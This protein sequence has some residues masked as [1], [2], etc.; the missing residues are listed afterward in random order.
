MSLAARISG[1]QPLVWAA[2]FAGGLALTAWLERSGRIGWP[3]NV[4]LIALFALSLPLMRTAS[5]NRASGCGTATLALRA[6]QNR[7]LVWALSYVALLGV[8]LTA[9]NT[10]HPAGPVLWLLALLPSLTIAYYVWAL[11]RYLAEEDDEYQRMRQVNSALIATGLLLV[12]ASTWG[13][14][15]TFGVAPH[16]EGWWSVAVWAV[17]LGLGN[18]VQ[19]LRERQ[20]DAA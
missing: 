19:T 14:L 1:R 20:D 12:V 7:S 17:G 6:Y 3:W 9:R 18:L 2:V 10:W 15:E 13:F 4:A 5:L 8:A 11:G 16:V